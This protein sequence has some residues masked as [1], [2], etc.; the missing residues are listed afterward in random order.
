MDEQVTVDITD[1]NPKATRIPATDVKVGD[2]VFDVYGGTHRIVSVRPLKDGGA[3]LRRED[4]EYPE[5]FALG[6][7][8]TIIPA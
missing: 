3:S 4:A 1:T 7:K 8:I 2:R 5:R 6:E